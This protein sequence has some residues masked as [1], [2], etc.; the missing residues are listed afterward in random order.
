MT[1]SCPRS[2]PSSS[3]HWVQVIRHRLN[4]TLCTNLMWKGQFQWRC[5]IIWKKKKKKWRVWNMLAD[6]PL[7]DPTL[8][9]SIVP[10]LM[11][12]PSEGEVRIAC[13]SIGLHSFF[14]FLM[15]KS[16]N[17]L[18]CFKSS[19]SASSKFTPKILY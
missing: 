6:N 5:K 2:H 7:T 3:A 10:K 1:V 8:L 14:N 15:K 13:G 11:I 16:F 4:T 12:F 18:Y 17:D 9:P 19:I